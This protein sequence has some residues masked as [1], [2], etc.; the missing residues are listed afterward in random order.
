MHGSHPQDKEN[1]QGQLACL[2]FSIA[3]RGQSPM[4]NGP[5][6]E[7]R[8]YT[9]RAGRMSAWSTWACSM[10]H[11]PEPPEDCT[12]VRSWSLSLSMMS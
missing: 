2:R 4:L 7:R 12:E 1:V 3:V 8:V 10:T 6:R 9:P 11:M 5:S